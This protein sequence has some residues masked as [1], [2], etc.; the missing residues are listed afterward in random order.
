MVILFLFIVALQNDDE[1]D[2]GFRFESVLAN[3]SAK[4]TINDK[5]KVAKMYAQKQECKGNFS[6]KYSF[7]H[8]QCTIDIL[9][10]S[11]QHS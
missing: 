3:P 10:S 7:I 9:L 8:V 4:L 2:V 1:I 5:H 6:D 11:N